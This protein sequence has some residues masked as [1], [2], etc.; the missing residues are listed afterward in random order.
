MLGLSR[1]CHGSEVFELCGAI[2]ILNA[3]SVSFATERPGSQTKGLLDEG[4][5]DSVSSVEA[6]TEANFDFF[7]LR[8]AVLGWPEVVAALV[9]DFAWFRAAPVFGPQLSIRVQPGE[10]SFDALPAVRASFTT[11]RNVVYQSDD[12][13]IVDYF[14][15]ALVVFDRARGEVSV[16]G[17]QQYLVHEAIYL[18]MLNRVGEHLDAAGLMRLHA[19]ALAGRQGGVVVLLPA[20]GGKSTLALR[21]LREDGVRLVSDDTPLLDRDSRLHAFPLRLGVNEVVAAQLP[22]SDVRRIERFEFPAKHALALEAFA[23]RIATEPSPLSHI[24]IGRRSLGTQARLTAIPR[25]RAVTPLFRDG[26]VGLGIAQMAE[27]VLQRGW[28]DVLAKGTVAG[29]RAAI[30]ASALSQARTWELELGRDGER[31]WVALE[32]LLL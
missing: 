27:Y 14:G 3:A 6:L 8:I 30:C 20:G 13:T 16:Q 9:L 32:S 5:M 17:D 4:E 12:R 24:V 29:R 11:T 23:Q 2:A 15:R 10:P 18:L 26:V 31:N 1:A 28:W 7:G 19:L 21:A 22:P 25:R